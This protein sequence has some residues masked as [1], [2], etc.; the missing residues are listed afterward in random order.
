M[1]AGS[2]RVRDHGAEREEVVTHAYHAGGAPKGF[3]SKGMF[4][5]YRWWVSEVAAFSARQSARGQLSTPNA[6]ASFLEAKNGSSFGHPDAEDEL[7]EHSG[8]A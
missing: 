1:L 7:V 2:I 6:L 3:V 8:Y 4:V 5:A